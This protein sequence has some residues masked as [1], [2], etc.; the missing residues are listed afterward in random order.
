MATDISCVKYKLPTEDIVKSLVFTGKYTKHG[1]YRS[2]HPVVKFTDGAVDDEDWFYR[3]LDE[4]NGPL[5]ARYDAS[6]FNTFAKDMA[7]VIV[8]SFDEWKKHTNRTEY[9]NDTFDTFVQKIIAMKAKQ[10]RFYSLKAQLCIPNFSNIEDWE[11]FEKDEDDFIP[12][13][14]M[15]C[16]PTNPP[17]RVESFEDK[18]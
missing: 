6:V 15:I 11:E 14:M 1:Q 8:L 18:S 2:H 10:D 12:G 13:G 5:V 4:Y 9:K 16:R 17:I 7:S 3:I